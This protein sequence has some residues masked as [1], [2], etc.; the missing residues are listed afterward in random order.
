[1]QNTDYYLL[2][3]FF[4]DGHKL[5]QNSLKE[6]VNRRIKP[7]IDQYAQNHGFPEFVFKEMGAWAYLA[8]FY[9]KSTEG[10]GLRSNFLWANDAGT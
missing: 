10:P 5:A 3:N 8:L 9:R 1:M 6:W 7:T 4:T 2:E